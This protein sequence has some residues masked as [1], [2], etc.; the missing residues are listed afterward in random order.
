MTTQHK[1]RENMVLQPETK[2]A[3][4][5]KDTNREDDQSHPLK[6]YSNFEKNKK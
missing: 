5:I 3:N 6:R 4:E 2:V 1:G